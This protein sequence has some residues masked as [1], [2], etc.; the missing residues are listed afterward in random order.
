MFARMNAGN[1]IIEY[2]AY[3]YINDGDNYPHFPSQSS[4]SSFDFTLTATPLAP[5]PYP[6]PD[7]SGCCVP[8]LTALPDDE[9]NKKL[10]SGWVDLQDLDLKWGYGEP[11]GLLSKFKAALSAAAGGRPVNINSGYRTCKY[12]NHLWEIVD[13]KN[14]LQGRDW[15]IN[16][17]E[18]CSLWFKTKEEYAGHYGDQINAK[19]SNPYYAGNKAMHTSGSAIDIDIKSL[20][21]SDDQIRTVLNNNDFKG[22]IGWG[23][24]IYKNRSSE[25]QHFELIPPIASPCGKMTPGP[26]PC[27]EV[28][29]I[30]ESQNSSPSVQVKVK[31]EYAEG[32]VVYYYTVINKSTELLTAFYIGYDDSTYGD[33]LLL[34]PLNYSIDNPS[35]ADSFISAAGW[36]GMVLDVLDS[37]YFNLFWYNS[38]EGSSIPPG[39]SL[40]GFKV[41]LPQASEEYA[42]GHFTAILTDGSKVSGP[43]QPSGNLVPYE[44]LLLD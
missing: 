21:L 1:Y 41:I 6:Y 20:G 19:V 11:N 5:C 38:V 33:E 15:L 30:A 43:L 24:D 31:R 44:L 27:S 36:E 23:S 13:R 39:G 16:H 9:T 42:K 29:Q 28:V 26:N 18:C 7:P 3:A 2:Y 17:P 40:S 8:G 37:P 35:P 10:N 25:A 22:I 34:S 4:Q 14:I 32:H 12:Q